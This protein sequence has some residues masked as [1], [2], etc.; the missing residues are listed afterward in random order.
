M[1]WYEAKKEFAC[2]GDGVVPKDDDKIDV[3]Y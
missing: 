2:C 3:G 1:R